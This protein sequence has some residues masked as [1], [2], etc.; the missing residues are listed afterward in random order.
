MNEKSKNAR[1][2]TKYENFRAMSYQKLKLKQQKNELKSKKFQNII[3]EKFYLIKK[4]ENRIKI[5]N[6]RGLALVKN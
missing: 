5:K 4:V 6:H 2:R 1:E 3:E